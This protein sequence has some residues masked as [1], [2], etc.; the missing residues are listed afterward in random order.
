MQRV[1]LEKHCTRLV[2]GVQALKKQVHVLIVEDK[3]GDKYDN[4]DSIGQAIKLEGERDEI[5]ALEYGV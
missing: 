4:H 5:D 2:L 1:Y 3:H